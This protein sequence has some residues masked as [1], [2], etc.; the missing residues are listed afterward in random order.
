ME[1]ISCIIDVSRLQFRINKFPEWTRHVR[2]GYSIL[3][4]DPQ[5]GQLYMAIDNERYKKTSGELG[6][7]D[8]A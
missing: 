2:F 3:A 8:G 5:S 1:T 6:A 7:I 4:S